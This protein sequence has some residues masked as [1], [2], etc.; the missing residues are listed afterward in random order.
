MRLED[1]RKMIVN[2]V[3]VSAFLRMR[4]EGETKPRKNKRYFISHF[5]EEYFKGRKFIKCTNCVE[6][7]YPI[8]FRNR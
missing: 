4:L 2:N 8:I 3:I 6:N 5:L 1:S 7:D